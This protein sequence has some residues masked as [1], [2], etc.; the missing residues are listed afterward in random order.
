[1][2]APAAVTVIGA[3]LAGAEATWQLANAGVDVTLVE[4]RPEVRTPA[5]STAAFAELVCSNSLGAD[6][7]TT[8]PGLLKEEMRALGSLVLECA[9]AASV[10]AGQALAVDRHAFSAE[11]TARLEN[12][13]KVHVVRQE[14]TAI[15]GSGIVVV[16][17]GPLTSEAMSSHLAAVLGEEHLFFFDAASPI[18]E[19][20]SVDWDVAYWASRYGRGEADYANCPMNEQE[21]DAFYKALV[22]AELAPMHEFESMKLFEACM[23]VE[24][25]ARR[26][27]DTLRFGPLK[28]VGLSDP[29]TGI[30]PHAVVQMRREDRDGALLN[31]VGFQTR[32]TWPS[33]RAVFRLI[34]GLAHAEFVRYGVMH[35][36][37]YINGPRHLLPT[38]QLRRN[39]RVLFAGQL[40]GVEGYMESA[41][42]GVVAGIN[43][44]RLALAR[45]PVAWPNTCCVGALC[46]HASSGSERGYQPK[47][48]SF[49]LLPQSPG[50]RR[51][52]DK[53]MRQMERARH[54]FAGALV[55]L[56]AG[57]ATCKAQNDATEADGGGGGA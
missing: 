21:Y 29:R 40:T 11:V 18:V 51:R 45:P 5:H 50:T 24:E 39:P 23:P 54:S 35:R 30:R 14:A 4:M 28:P 16:A 12:H 9:E 55:D 47:G 56:R 10:A 15:P 19:A 49:G 38:L 53:R 31:L 7:E 25:I 52:D 34:P 6:R 2:S 26:G 32:L 43:A 48:I 57:D 13:S 3:G 37:T 41:A 17:T 8:A 36:N 33:Q 46:A 22:A 27:R 44:A 20:D 42:T 1:M